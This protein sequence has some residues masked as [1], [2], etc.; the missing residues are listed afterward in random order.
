MGFHLLDSFSECDIIL[1]E[2]GKKNFFT[3]Y[4]NLPYKGDNTCYDDPCDPRWAQTAKHTIRY[5]SSY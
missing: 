2:K 4:P 5:A 3:I 1:D